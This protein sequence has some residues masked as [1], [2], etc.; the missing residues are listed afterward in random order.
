M[1]LPASRNTTY[2]AGATQIKAADLN[3]L[4][5]Y[6][7]GHSEAHSLWIGPPGMMN[8]DTGWSVDPSGSAVLPNWISGGASA[9]LI[10]PV[11]LWYGTTVKHKLTSLAVK[12]KP[13]ASGVLTLKTWTVDGMAT[14]ATPG[15]G[16]AQIGS[17]QSSSGTSWQTLTVT[18]LTASPTSN[19]LITAVV[20][21]AQASDKVIG[22]LATYTTIDA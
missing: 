4:Q 7:V 12:L 22:A 20:I 1:A 2:V 13:N 16:A 19:V 5:D 3:G 14:T 10:I 15:A 21:S 18:G 11:P 17:T 9:Y 6:I 8:S